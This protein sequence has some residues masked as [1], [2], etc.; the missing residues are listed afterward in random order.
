MSKQVFKK[1]QNSYTAGSTVAPVTFTPPA[2]PFQC[3]VFLVE[4][5]VDKQTQ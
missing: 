3:Y 2:R 4:V 5:V 1:S